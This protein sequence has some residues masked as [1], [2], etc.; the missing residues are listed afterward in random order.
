MLK[1]IARRVLQMVPV[2]FGV[3]ILLFVLT[4]VLPGD[5]IAMRMGERNMSDA[6]R[7]AARKALGLDK[8]IYVQYAD[9]IVRLSKGDL[10]ESYRQKRPVSAVFGDLY[11]NTAKLAVVARRPSARIQGQCGR[12]GKSDLPVAHANESRATPPSSARK[13]A[14]RNGGAKASPALIVA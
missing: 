7:L 6:Q 2:F 1:Y 3:T 8:P 13:P 14:K 5:P 10:G 4:V 9:Y 12:S 11:P